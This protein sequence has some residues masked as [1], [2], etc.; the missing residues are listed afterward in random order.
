MIYMFMGVILNSLFQMLSQFKAFA[1]FLFFVSQLSAQEVSLT[2]LAPGYSDKK[3]NVWLEDDLFTGHRDLISSEYLENDSAQFIIHDQEIVLIRIELDYQYALMLIEPNKNYRVIFPSPNEKSALTLAKKTR[4]QLIYKDLDNSDINARVSEFNLLVDQFILEN[5]SVEQVHGTDTSIA[6]E[7]ELEEMFDD[8][9]EIKS[10]SERGFLKKLGNF[11]ISMDSLYG[12]D[13]SYFAV[14]RKYVFANL[15]YSLGKKRRPL[16]YDYLQDQPVDYYNVEFVK[17]FNAFY[18]D[19]FDFYSFY[20][21]SE[22]LI[23]ALESVK[24]TE[25]LLDLIRGD[26]LTGLDE[27]QHLILIK[28]LYDLYPTTSKWKSRIIEILESLKVDNPYTNQRL[29]AQYMVEKL[30][31]GKQGTPIPEMTYINE[32]GDTLNVAN[33]DNTVVYIQFF[34]SWN[35]SALA[36]MELMTE[37]RKKYSNMVRFLSISID[38]NYEDFKTFV[39]NNKSFKWDFGWVGDDPVIWQDFEIDHLPLFYLIDQHGKIIS[40]PSLWPSTGIESNFYKIKYNNKE[41]KKKGYWDGAPNKSNKD[42]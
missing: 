38:E 4:V 29:I 30:L 40:W 24:P 13:G 32:S 7:P 10:F 33:L 39:E 27:M 6:F 22:K 42:G 9:Y 25:S 41:K 21:Y 35:T 36:E 28:G 26:T 1:F 15:E 23:S 12:Y 37:L 20:P 8:R 19:F 3:V 17:F 5:L 14:Y 16:F 31:K 18:K 11:K 2:V 34:A